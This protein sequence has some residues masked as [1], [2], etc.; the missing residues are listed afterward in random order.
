MATSNNNQPQVFVPLTFQKRLTLI[1]GA[2]FVLTLAAVAL[3]MFT[4]IERNV[5]T[6]VTN[7]LSVS[8]SVFERLLHDRLDQMQEVASLMSKD[9]GFRQSVATADSPTVLSALRNLANRTPTDIAVVTDPNGSVIASLSDVDRAAVSEFVQ[10]LSSRPANDNADADA[11][12]V[13]VLSDRLYA[14]V[15]FPVVAPVTVGWFISG[16]A[17]DGDVAS[18]IEQLSAIPLG[19]AFLS[20]S[21][22]PGQWSLYA[23]TGDDAPLNTLLSRDLMRLVKAGRATVDDDTYLIVWMGLGGVDANHNAGALLYYSEDAALSQFSPLF[24]TLLMIVVVGVL[25]VLGGSQLVSR[26]VTKPLRQLVAAAG[27]IA[28]GNYKPAPKLQAQEFAEL[29]NGFDSMVDAVREREDQIREQAYQDP[30][31]RLPNRLGLERLVSQQLKVQSSDNA[32]I[33]VIT[34]E[35]DGFQRLRS[36]LTDAIAN[37]LIHQVANE[38]TSVTKTNVCRISTS[39]LGF[40]MHDGS[41]VTAVI[42]AIQ[43]RFSRAISCNDISVDIRLTLGVA[44]YPVHATSAPD[45]VR[46]SSAAVNQASRQSLSSAVFSSDLDDR[47]TTQLALMSDLRTAIRKNELSLYLHPKLDVA[48]GRFTS[49]EALVRWISDKHGFMPPDTFIP[50]AESTGDIRYLTSWVLERALESALTLNNAGIEMNIAVNLSAIDL[51]NVDL[52]DTLDALLKKTGAAPQML[53]LEVTESAVMSDMARALNTLEALSAMGFSLALDDYGTGY[54]SLSYLKRLP[55]DELKIDKSFVQELASDEEDNILVRSTIE[56]GHNLGLKI[57]AE[58]VE[59]TDSVARL[60][61]YGCDYL[62]GF[63]YTKPLPLDDARAF[64]DE[65]ATLAV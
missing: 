19:V 13:L 51:I 60:K 37:S 40:L 11:S 65:H 23:Q 7:D 8:A 6:R 46:C 29:A 57:T 9:F 12:R 4:T 62:Q 63:Y 44:S 56:L 31:T 41:D 38:L 42:S 39:S 24:E 61:T 16:L 54:S 15:A 64:L 34:A 5:T 2:L 55:V 3:A 21:G 28:S 36:T 17:L 10:K 26:G 27:E 20:G 49:A 1:F 33:H 50:I 45:L 25:L 35:V 53:S 30:E 58:G 43:D 18:E 32:P 48:T 22:A 47:Q 59:D 52:P 14:V